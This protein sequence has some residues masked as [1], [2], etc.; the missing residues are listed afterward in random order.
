MKGKL[1]KSMNYGWM[2]Q[3][4]HCGIDNISYYP[5]HPYDT[6]TNSIERVDGKEVE[7]YVDTFWETGLEQVI[8][9]A[10]I[11]DAPIEEEKYIV[12]VTEVELPQQEIS[13][14]EIEKETKNHHN[15]YEWSAGA[16]WYREQLKQTKKD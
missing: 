10:L 14:E 16:K 8:K 3:H 13:D 5:L 11:L 9:V 2:V 4:E 12:K 7:F 1:H 6:I 15:Y